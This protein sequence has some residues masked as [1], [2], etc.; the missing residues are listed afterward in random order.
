MGAESVVEL[1]ALG[2]TV[3]AAAET[4]VT[5]PATATELA[6]NFILN[7][8]ELKRILKVMKAVVVVVVVVS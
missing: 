5:K 4:Y 6:R 2:N 7:E 3:V 1:A 8:I